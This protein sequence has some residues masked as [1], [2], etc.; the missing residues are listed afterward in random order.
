MA[1]KKVNPDE[2]VDP[3]DVRNALVDSLIGS[4]FQLSATGTIFT[5][6]TE[7]N[8]TWED[9]LFVLN[10]LYT[11]GY[12][13]EFKLLPFNVEPAI[14]VSGLSKEVV[15]WLVPMLIHAIDRKVMGSEID[16]L[17]PNNKNL[18]RIADVLGWYWYKHLHGPKPVISSLVDMQRPTKLVQNAY[19]TCP[20]CFHQFI[21]APGYTTQGEKAHAYAKW[22]PYHLKEYH[23][24]NDTSKTKSSKCHCG[25]CTGKF[26]V[27][28][29]RYNKKKGGTK[30]K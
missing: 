13:E 16:F 25:F 26:K 1:T 3:L 24:M 11:T 7:S 19:L 14:L 9:I 15:A 29:P 23:R 30:A 6:G 2:E 10:R 4:S 17:S 22:L 21:P 5:I 27:Y 8:P 12:V 18:V 20:L 28:A